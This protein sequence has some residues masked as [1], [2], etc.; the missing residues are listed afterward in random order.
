M[1]KQIIKKESGN[2]Y[3][4]GTYR[5]WKQPSGGIGIKFDG[6]KELYGIPK[7]TDL[8]HKINKRFETEK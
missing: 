2:E 1:E 4:V 3:I 7:G 5:I 8:Y 6:E